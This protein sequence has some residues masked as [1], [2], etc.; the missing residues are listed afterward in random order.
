MDVMET[1]ADCARRNKVVRIQ[2]T[3]LTT[4]E[5]KTYFIE[6]YSI[7]QETYLFGYDTHEGKIKKFHISNILDAQETDE[8]FYPRWSVEF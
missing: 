6:P 7:R 3:K 8:E 4:G 5:T 2:Y 1:I